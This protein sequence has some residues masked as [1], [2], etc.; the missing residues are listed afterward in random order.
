MIFTI[1]ET[2]FDIV[3]K[4]MNPI[5]GKVGGS[6][7]NSAVSIA[8]LGAHVSFI[9]EMGADIVGTHCI[10]FI[11][12]QG[13]HTNYITVNS[14]H[15]TSLALAFLNEANDATYEFHKQLPQEFSCNP[16]EF[17]SED[18]VL[19]SSSFALSQRTRKAL[20]MILQQAHSLQTLVVYDPNIRKAI[21]PNSIE[22]NYI[23]ENFAHAHIVRASD[24][25]IV[26]IFGTMSISNIYKTLKNKGVHI[27]IVT[28]NSK[29][30]TV[31]TP[32]GTHH[33][34]VPAIEPVSTIGAGDTFNAA[35][36]FALHQARI[37]NTMLN[38]LS[39][40]FWNQTIPFAIR[41]ASQVC[42]SLDNYV[43]L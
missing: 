1:G 23:H 29:G 16:I 9:S 40:D 32:Q 2:V 22:W 6:A 21:Q 8:R 15:P 37:R 36:L 4:D 38:E 7:L 43:S 42:L 19:F 41:C 31:Y 13:V 5:A 35:L 14:A 25:D 20:N 12:Q 30:V 27:L 39:I 26:H 10:Q 3:F 11:A 34:P 18:Y 24:E 28:Q 33:Y 17:S